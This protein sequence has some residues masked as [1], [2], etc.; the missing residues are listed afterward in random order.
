PAI[1]R[2]WVS[3][4]ED[5]RTD[6]RTWA[7]HV[8]TIDDEWTPVHFELGFGL[9]ERGAARDDASR[10]EEVVLLSGVRLKGSIDLV[11]RHR[12]TGLMRITDHKT[13]RPLEKAPMAVGGGA[14]L[15]PLLYSLA[16]EQ[17]LGQPVSMGRLFYC[18]QRG[19]YKEYSVPVKPIARQ[20]LE[21]VLSGIDEALAQ[22]FLPAAPARE[23]C[24][25]CDYERVCGP[26]EEERLRRKPAARIDALNQLRGLP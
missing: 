3:E 11:E 22:G 6:L 8:A 7:R 26:R 1:E 12:E 17:M 13:G 18:T 9:K 19:G 23:A 2:V 4:I 16:A 5:M 20:H 10:V 25:M 15:Q 14:V 21:Q 24:G